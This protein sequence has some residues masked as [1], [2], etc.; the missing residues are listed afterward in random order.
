MKNIKSMLPLM[1][2]TIAFLPVCLQAQDTAMKMNTP[3]KMPKD[4]I[5]LVSTKMDTMKMGNQDKTQMDTMAMD[6]KNM[7]P[8]GKMMVPDLTTWPE[9]SQMAAKEM[10][11]K[12]GQ[13]Q[14][15]S[16]RM[17]VW[18]NNGIW[19]RTIVYKQEAQHDFPVPHKDVVQ[20][21]I[22]YKVPNLDKVDELA[23][24]DGSVVVDRT[25]G[26]ISARCDKEANNILALNLANDVATGK[27]TVMEARDT[28]A[29]MVAL[30]MKGEKPDYIQKLMF[31]ANMNAA[32]AD[33]VWEKS[34]MPMK[35]SSKTSTKTSMNES[36]MN[37]QDSTGGTKMKSK[38]DAMNNGK[39]KL[40]V[41]MADGKM[42]QMKDG[43]M[44]MMDQ[45]LKFSNGA[46]VM[47]NGTMKMKDGKTMKLKDGDCVM[48]DGTMSH[49]GMKKMGKGKM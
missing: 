4:T 48:M 25:Q 28:Y 31:S 44:M 45:D 34:K 19:K 32:D 33:M 11:D 26:E 35:A 16:D 24:F 40:C 37:T 12:Y 17:L 2:A 27:K 21:F 46:T 41:K 3:N 7:M 30:E 39:A 10:T 36:S 14:I 47:T 9:A 6:H 42:M 43:K 38:M 20:Q 29:K 1:I 15:M 18:A 23:K 22:S 49:M 8:M 13:P 5:P